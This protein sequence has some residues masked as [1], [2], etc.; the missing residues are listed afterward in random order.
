MVV[1]LSLAAFKV[2]H[3]GL[4]RILT[5]HA[6]TWAV[7]DFAI[8]SRERG[9]GYRGIQALEYS[10]GGRGDVFFF[11]VRYVDGQYLC[12]AALNHKLV[13]GV[14]NIVLVLQVS[15]RACL[16]FP[17]CLNLKDVRRHRNYAPLEPSA[18]H[19]DPIACLLPQT[20]APFTDCR[21]SC[22]ACLRR[23]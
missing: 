17:R 2:W 7:A 10:M 18:S 14:V 13:L 15:V 22:T 20:H 1:S 16:D 6:T 4:P 5:A 11:H 8:L 23:V 12:D 9:F 21:W 3:L 19:F